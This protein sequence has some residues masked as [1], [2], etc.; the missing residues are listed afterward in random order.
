M[1]WYEVAPLT[2]SH[3][4]VREPSARVTATEEG[5]PGAGAGVGVGSGSGGVNGPA[6]GELRHPPPPCSFFARTPT[7]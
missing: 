5:V 2:A 6:D 4:A 1:T 3:D 7:T